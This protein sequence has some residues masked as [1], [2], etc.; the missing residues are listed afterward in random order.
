M[1]E[2]PPGLDMAI[3]LFCVACMEGIGSI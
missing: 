2:P 1:G 3:Y